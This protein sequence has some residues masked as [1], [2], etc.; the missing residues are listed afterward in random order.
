MA[1]FL[2]TFVR[3]L[4][5]SHILFQNISHQSNALY[6]SRDYLRLCRACSVSLELIS[7]FLNLY[8]LIR[9]CKSLR[10]GAADQ[11]GNGY[12]RPQLSVW[13]SLQES[14][15]RPMLTLC[16]FS[17]LFFIFIVPGVVVMRQSD[18]EQSGQIAQEENGTDAKRADAEVS[19]TNRIEP[20]GTRAK[21]KNENDRR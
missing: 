2:A 14:S 12:R 15:R 3:S 11:E 20:S 13:D 16:F 10:L 7:H 6:A 9:Y 4:R 18:S 17:E 21:T 8:N 5:E 1:T 19:V